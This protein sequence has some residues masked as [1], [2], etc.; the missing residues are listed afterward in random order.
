MKPP[1]IVIIKDLDEAG[2]VQSAPSNTPRLPKGFE[3]LGP[4]HVAIGI[5]EPGGAL[6]A[7]NAIPAPTENTAG[8]ELTSVAKAAVTAKPKALEP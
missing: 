7:M 3:C 6:L 2:G 5:Q 4:I 8:I 1:N